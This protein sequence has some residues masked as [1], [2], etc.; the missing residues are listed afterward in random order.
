MTRIRYPTTHPWWQAVWLLLCFIPLRAEGDNAMAADGPIEVGIG[1]F[2]LDIPSIEDPADRF[3]AKIFL[4]LDW[5]DAQL[6]FDAQEAGHDRKIFTG[7]NAWNILNQIWWPDLEIVNEYG[8]QNVHNENLTIHAD[9]LVIY[10]RLL[11]A[12]LTSHLDLSLSPL[13]SKSWPSRSNR[14]VLIGAPSR[15]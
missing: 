11:E 12:T 1:V 8:Q 2:I 15:L 10:S 9:G 5:R 6:A 7:G 3:E 4:E 13:T 14:P